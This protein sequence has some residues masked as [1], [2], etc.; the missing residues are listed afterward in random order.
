M[1]ENKSLFNLS[2]KLEFKNCFSHLIKKKKKL[3]ILEEKLYIILICIQRETLVIILWFPKHVSL[4]LHKVKDLQLHTINLF[5][6]LKHTVPV[7]V[8]TSI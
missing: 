2:S 3:E 4:Y 7:V 6:S 1:T 8:K 5:N